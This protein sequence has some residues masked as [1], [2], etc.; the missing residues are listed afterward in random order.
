LNTNA[1]HIDNLIGRYLSAEATSEEKALVEEWREQNDGNRRYFE[2]MKTIFEKAASAPVAEIFDPDEAWLKVK[3]QL[4]RRTEISKATSAPTPA[5]GSYYW[6]MAAGI[7]FFL[8]VGLL[9]YRFLTSSP[10]LQLAAHDNVERDTL[11]DG[12]TLVLNKKTTVQYIADRQTRV[13]KLQGEAYF[14]VSHDRGHQFVVNADEIFIQDIGTS[15]NVSAYPDSSTVEVLVDEGEVR[16]YS[17]ENAGVNLTA[18]QMGIYN[19]ITRTFSMRD[20]RPNITA[21]KTRSFTFNND[22]LSTVVAALNRVYKTKIHIDA[23]LSSCRLTVSFKNEKIQEI[24]QV[25]AETLGLTISESTDVIEL[26]GAGCKGEND[27]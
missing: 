12:S 5:F 3:A 4:E 15:F 11:P 10:S 19:K 9:A 22:S 13:A 20:A 2:Q 25:I 14:N 18:G 16:F 8:T 27:E 23:N 17:K 7:A 21:Y 6:K 1:N 24:A 26:K